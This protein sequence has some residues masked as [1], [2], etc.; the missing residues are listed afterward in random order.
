MAT[1]DYKIPDFGEQFSQQN[2]NQSVTGTTALDEWDAMV[3]RA[4]R[5]LTLDDSAY[6]QKNVDQQLASRSFVD[7]YWLKTKLYGS[8][9]VT[10]SINNGLLGSVSAQSIACCLISSLANLDKKEKDNILKMTKKERE[11]VDNVRSTLVIILSVLKLSRSYLEKGLLKSV[12]DYSF[13]FVRMIIESITEMY[14]AILGELLRKMQTTLLAKLNN[15]IVKKDLT[16]LSCFGFL[17]LLK[18][19]FNT[20]FGD[21]T[22]IVYQFRSLLYTGLNWMDKRVKNSQAEI[23]RLKNLEWLDFLILVVGSIIDAIDRW[24]MCAPDTYSGTP[25]DQ[26]DSNVP[27]IND[28][29]PG[30][31]STDSSLTGGDPDRDSNSRYTYADYTNS[32]NNNIS[33]DKT[34]N[35][36]LS[37][38]TESPY[39]GNAESYGQPVIDASRLFY[40]PSASELERFLIYYLDVPQQ[41]AKQAAQASIAGQC[42]DRLS[43]Q[44]AKQV[45]DLLNKLGIS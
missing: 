26:K 13:N 45:S 27:G 35:Q 34:N 4:I 17:S 1:S 16:I 5:S 22:G 33:I 19:M 38:V 43:A 25:K 44:D 41:E 7:T 24:K 29:L 12:L 28:E 31:G 37:G 3:N 40:E 39:T 36:L 23:L 9:L 42:S 14:V 18:F 10:D 2:L 30:N 11:D 21:V 20:L 32:R 6:I 15:Y 8:R